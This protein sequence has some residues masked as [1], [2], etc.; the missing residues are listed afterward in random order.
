[1]TELINHIIIIKDNSHEENTSRLNVET[2][3]NNYY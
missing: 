2:I 3:S 1:M